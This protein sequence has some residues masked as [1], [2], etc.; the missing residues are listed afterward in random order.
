MNSTNKITLRNIAEST[1]G[2]VIGDENFLISGVCSLENSKKE[3]ITFFKGISTNAFQLL[4]NKTK[5]SAI[6]IPQSL[7]ISDLSNPSAV[8]LIQVPDSQRAFID[9]VKHFH[10]PIVPSFGIH[11]QASIAE[12]TTIGNNSQ[13]GPFSFIG[14]NCKIGDNVTIHPNVTIY[15][16]VEIGN[17]SI[18]HSGV[19][20]REDVKIASNITIQNGA[21]IGADGFG[22]ISDK[23]QGLVPVPQVGNVVLKDHVD[24]GANACLDR[25]TIDSTTIGLGTKIDNLV[26]IGHN[27]E[28][29]SFSIV[30]GQA[31]I[32]GSS[33]IGNQ[34][35]LGGNV[36]VA[37]HTEVA[38]GCRFAA[39]SGLHGKY[40]EKGDYGG[41]PA[42][43][44]RTYR[45]VVSI[46]PKLPDLFKSLKK[47]S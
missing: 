18:I 22:Y 5:V 36:G 34:V 7:S 46:L 15:H 47:E 2:I 29:G 12:S 1:N 42:L 10:P 44:A 16:N 39:F 9:I 21:I 19:T 33:K 40:T 6:F 3:H 35:V 41:N 31:A 20:I 28:I 30:C 14:E 43:P 37:D 24:I 8:N 45:K 23:L 17:N 13:V 11:K 26:Q 27:T 32:A 4:L 25:A 38:D